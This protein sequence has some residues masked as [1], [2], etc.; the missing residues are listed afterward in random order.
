MRLSTLEYRE[1][2]LV[3]LL[4]AVAAAR[5]KNSLRAPKEPLFVKPILYNQNVANAS[6]R[7]A[8][9]RCLLKTHCWAC[10]HT[11]TKLNAHTKANTTPEQIKT[12]TRTHAAKSTHQKRTS[13]TH[14]HENTCTQV[15]THVH[16]PTE[17]TYQ[18]HSP[19]SHRQAHA[20]KHG[21][22]HAPHVLTH[23]P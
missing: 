21:H 9:G 13:H 14:V 22:T 12:H 11:N 8:H 19:N 7:M 17:R 1:A 16:P 5:S 20:H 15:N 6:T 2:A 10:A 4:I 3:Q 23:A 18:K